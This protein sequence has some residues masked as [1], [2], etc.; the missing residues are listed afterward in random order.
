MT[1]FCCYATL[2]LKM[3]SCQVSWIKI[4]GCLG[5]FLFLKGKNYLLLF[6]ENGFLGVGCSVGRFFVSGFAD[7]FLRLAC[8]F[9]FLISLMFICNVLQF[10]SWNFLGIY[11]LLTPNVRSL[12]FFVPTLSFKLLLLSYPFPL[13]RLECQLRWWKIPIY[14]VIFS[15]SC[16]L[17]RWFSSVFL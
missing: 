3:N 16:S 1:F 2:S 6:F 11:P 13:K 17:K 14:L 12:L 7:T 10:C 8:W 15:L 5:T 9:A 4:V